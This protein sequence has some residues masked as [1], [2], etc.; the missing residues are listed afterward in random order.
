MN[1]CA[2]AGA[3]LDIFIYFYVDPCY[4]LG[5]KTR[6]IIGNSAVSVGPE[7]N[8]YP[9]FIQDCLTVDVYWLNWI[10]TIFLQSPYV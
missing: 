6:N 10:I 2:L 1:E 4:S 8:L 5:P 3:Q 9:H 7:C